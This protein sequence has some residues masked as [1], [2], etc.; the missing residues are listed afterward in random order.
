M[1]SSARLVGPALFL[2]SL[3][4]AIP[5]VSLASDTSRSS[6]EPEAATG[7]SV[8]AAPKS[9]LAGRRYMAV[10]ANPLASQAAG[11]VLAQGGNALDAALAAQWVLNLVEPQSSGIGGGAFL[12][13][14]DA[15]THS[16]SAWDGR[17]TA[18]G[19]ATEG[20]ARQ[21]DG[22]LA[23]FDDL[24]LGG[25]AV[26]TPGLVSML[27]E[28]HRH[29]GRRP[30][31]SS[32][33]PAIRLADTGFSVS[34]RLHALLSQDTLL[35]RDPAA[36]ALYYRPDG[37]AVPVGA[38]V[39]NPA[40]ASTFRRIAQDKGDAFYQGS[41]ATSIVDAVTDRGGNL[42]LADM[43]AYQPRRRE[44]VCGDYRGYRICGMPPPS[45][46]G[47]AVAQLL[48]ILERTGTALRHPADAESVHRFA[49]AGR[50]VYADRARYLADPDF[51][52]IP[53]AE[54]LSPRYLDMRA[55]Q[56]DPEHSMGM[57]AP[58]EQLATDDLAMQTSEEIP[59][60]THLSIVDAEG[61]AVALTSSIEA[62]FGSRLMV[63]GFLL[64][65]QLTDFSWVA[66]RDGKPV[67]NRLQPGKRPLS[68]MAP[69]LVFAPNGQLWAVLGSSGGQR[70]INYVA[71]TLVVL[72]DG[73][74]TPDKALE[75]P[76]A[77]SRNGPTEL[78][79][80]PAAEAFAQAL[81][82]RGHV[83]KLDEMTSGTHLIVR[84][85]AGRGW[86]GAADPRR[87]GRA[88]GN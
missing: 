47:I 3:C 30:W 88:V 66:E 1:K 56:I 46:G 29:H 25:R 41:L 50:L 32:F 9:A 67:A 40:L 24:I 76:H 10:T 16:L 22:T 61:N 31:A 60:T 58:G 73:G 63:D 83:V 57:A 48:G 23:G 11:E 85:P 52:K 19:Q 87:E 36:T 49:E 43:A 12:L 71:R 35:R 74:L 8:E 34:P 27:V 7:R 82:A 39:R 20:F 70:I 2:F 4:L 45:S 18:P 72:I 64:N 13:Y 84:D 68:S 62:A 44:A 77:G 80:S 14:W 59:A 33:D 53:Q 79:I 86:L 42:T 54:L 15:R 75:L 69:T 65:N 21:A 55:R 17:E 26:G 6:F 81:R 78:E 28:A 37:S 51:I 5:A 38:L